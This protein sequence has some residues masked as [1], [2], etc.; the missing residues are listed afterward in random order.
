MCRSGTGCSRLA[1]LYCPSSSCAGRHPSQIPFGISGSSSSAYP[2]YWPPRLPGTLPA[3]AHPRSPQW[4][5]VSE[6][7]WAH[8]S[9]HQVDASILEELNGALG[10]MRACQIRPEEVVAFRVVLI[11]KGSDSVDDT[12]FPVRFAIDVAV[13]WQE[14]WLRVGSLADRYPH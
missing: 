3:S 7:Q 2:H 13:F 12:L 5:E 10:V 1:D 6:Q 9:R 11:K 8:F 4:G 14:E